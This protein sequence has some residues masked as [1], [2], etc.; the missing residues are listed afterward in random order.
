MAIVFAL[1][2]W[3][4]YLLGRQFEVK[5]DQRSLKFFLEQR[6][7][8][9]EH[10]KWLTKLMGFN[11]HIEYHLGLQNKA[12]NTLTRIN[13]TLSFMSLSVRRAVQL[14]MI[15][16]EV[17]ADSELSKLV[18]NGQGKPPRQD[19]RYRKAYSLTGMWFYLKIVLSY[20]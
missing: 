6:T 1:Q 2:K 9:E 8:N 4:N 18:S 14:E 5:T 17:T 16:K 20:L 19:T 15:P 7:V 13:P 12:D 3:R 10:Q 11:F